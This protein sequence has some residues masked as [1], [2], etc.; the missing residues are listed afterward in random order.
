MQCF[1]SMH[2]YSYSKR[3]YTLKWGGTQECIN[4][5]EF[6]SLAINNTLNRHKLPRWNRWYNWRR[7]DTWWVNRSLSWSMNRSLSWRLNRSFGWWVSHWR[8]SKLVMV[9]VVVMMVRWRGYRRLVRRCMVGWLSPAHII[10]NII[11]TKHIYYETRAQKHGNWK[12]NPKT[13]F[14]VFVLCVKWYRW[15]WWYIY[16]IGKGKPFT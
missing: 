1:I 7:W 10:I 14:D 15:G 12:Q 3:E 9:V 5:F 16:T 11:S 4:S 6:A 13:H 2:A 8:R